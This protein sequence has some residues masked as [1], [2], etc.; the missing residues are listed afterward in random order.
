MNDPKFKQHGGAPAARHPQHRPYW[1]RMH[2]S[3]FFWVAA[4]C[5]LGT[6]IVYVITNNLAFW[7]GEK[8]QAAVPA[9]AP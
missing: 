6:M 9:I 3:P 4:F 8:A 7:P 5:L 1:K 2:R